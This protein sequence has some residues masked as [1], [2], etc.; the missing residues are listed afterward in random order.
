MFE[1]LVSS[2]SS[3]RAANRDQELGEKG[4]VPTAKK[5][6]NSTMFQNSKEFTQLGTLAKENRISEYYKPDIPAQPKPL[7]DPNDLSYLTKKHPIGSQL[8]QE[9]VDVMHDN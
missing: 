3:Q 8:R 9:N 2:S 6:F 7:Q 5:F 1:N 4:Y